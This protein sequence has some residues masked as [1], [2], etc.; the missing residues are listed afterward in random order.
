MEDLINELSIRPN[1]VEIDD[2]HRAVLDFGQRSAEKGYLTWRE[3]THLLDHMS[4]LPL[5]HWH[6]FDEAQAQEATR[7]AFAQRDEP[8]EA[9]ASLETL[10]GVAA[11]AAS[12]ILAWTDPDRFAAIDEHAWRTLR[13]FG[14]VDHW[15]QGI[16]PGL[17]DCAAFTEI[18]RA[19]G[20]RLDRPAHWVDRW[21]YTSDRLDGGTWH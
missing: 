16:E 20:Q 6:R 8:F 14:L 4:H 21:L 10:P 19:V 5:R 13:R 7:T 3:L 11:F 9:L 12:A 1:I 17:Q 15:S 2:R 18:C